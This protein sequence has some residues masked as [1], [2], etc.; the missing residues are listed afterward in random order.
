M[1]TRR[2]LGLLLMIFVLASETLPARTT[3][4]V[5]TGGGRDYVLESSD[6]LPDLADAWLGDR[7][8]YPAILVLTNQKALADASY[9]TISDPEEVSPGWKIY[10]PSPDEAQE[11]MASVQVLR[12]ATTSSTYDSGLLEAILPDFERHFNAQVDVIAVGTGQALTIGGR[13]DADVVLVHAPASEEGFVANGDGINRLDVMYND[14][15]IVGPR[16]DPASVSGANTAREAFARIAASGAVFVSRGDNSG[17]HTKELSIWASAGIT[18]T[19]ESGWYL[20][21]GQGMGET[22]LFANERSAYTLSDRGTWLTQRA[23]LPDLT[24]LVGGASIEQNRD[25]VL[26]NPYGVIPVNP[27]R[28][29]GVNYTLAMQFARWITCARVQAMIEAFGKDRF[30]QSLFCPATKTLSHRTQ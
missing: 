13:G 9:A 26:L 18:P 28:H 30:G 16:D 17:T 3:P 21:I 25:K 19:I 8:A 15:V 2:I 11:F 5:Q 23:S 27:A 24:V 20:S 4:G 7:A 10:L 12:L 1:T 6:T 14:F 22:L 29:P